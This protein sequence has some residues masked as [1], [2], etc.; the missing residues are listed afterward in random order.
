[1]FDSQRYFGTP[2]TNIDSFGWAANGNNN[3]DFRDRHNGTVNCAF[4]DGHVKAL[5]CAD[6]FPCERGEWLG[7]A[8]AS[9]RTCWNSGWTPNY[10]SDDG[11]TTPKN[12]CP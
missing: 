5:R 11:K 9:V 10:T 3:A 1:M 7:Q 12:R 4:C 8:T 2:E 6:M